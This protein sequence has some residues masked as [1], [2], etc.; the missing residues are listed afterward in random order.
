MLG[1]FNSLHVS[2]NANKSKVYFDKYLV[3]EATS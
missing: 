3:T 1:R 2:K